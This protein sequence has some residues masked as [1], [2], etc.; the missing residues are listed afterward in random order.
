[1][2]AAP[3]PKVDVQQPAG[4]PIKILIVDDHPMMRAG[5]RQTL[6]TEFKDAILREACDTQQA[7]E[8]V[9]KEEWDIVLLDITMPGRS[10]LDALKEVK[11]V[12]PKLPVLIVSVHA[13][14]Q[15]AIRVLQ[16]GASGYLTKETAGSE[17]VDAVKRILGGGKYIRAS[18]AEKLAGHVSRGAGDGQLHD[19]LSDRE[20]QVMC[21][22][23]LGKTVKEISNELSLSI[24][25]ISTYRTRILKKT[26]L[27]NNSEIMRYAVEHELV[28][29]PRRQ[30]V[31]E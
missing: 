16:R 8:Q 30:V 7:L 29:F 6:A 17:L 2:P 22:L 11:K 20:Y 27:K 10:G 31:D 25:T 24:K 19:P 12:N 4:R 21:M 15:F 14:E 18:L 26:G 23:A 9:W 1:M 3:L 13:E 28:D 5:M